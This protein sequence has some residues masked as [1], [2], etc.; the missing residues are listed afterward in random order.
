V[1]DSKAR[2]I[3]DSDAIDFEVIDF[4]HG[5]P[6]SRSCSIGTVISCSTSWADRPSASAWT[7]TWV[8]LNS[9]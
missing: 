1:P 5:T 3:T 8:S 2:S 7:S 6:L 4:S 9:G